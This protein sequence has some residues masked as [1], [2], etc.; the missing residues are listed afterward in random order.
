[1][2]NLVDLDHQ[3]R[4]IGRDDE[5]VGVSLDEQPGFLLVRVAQ[6]FASLDGFGEAGVEVFGLSDASAVRAAS[7]EIGQAVA[8]SR[9]LLQAVHRAGEHQSERV[10]ARSVRAGKNDG[11]RKAVAR[12]H[13]A[14]PMDG[15]RVAHE[16]RKWHKKA[17]GR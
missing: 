16:F 6:I 3:L 11:V 7:A 1:M 14:Q 13:L 5:H 8:V 9:R 12:Q 17:S 15:F 4:W 2:P 10:L